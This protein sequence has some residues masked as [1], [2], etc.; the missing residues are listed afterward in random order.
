[1]VGAGLGDDYLGHRWAYARNRRQLLE[2]AGERAHLLLDP[3]RKFPDRGGELVKDP[4]PFRLRRLSIECGSPSGPHRHCWLSTTPW[5]SGVRN[6]VV[7]PSLCDGGVQRRVPNA[8]RIHSI[9][10]RSSRACTTSW[11]AVLVTSSPISHP[12]PYNVADP[13]GHGLYVLNRLVNRD[14]HRALHV[15]AYKDGSIRSSERARHRA[16][17]RCPTAKRWCGS[18]DGQSSSSTTKRGAGQMASYRFP[19]GGRIG[20]H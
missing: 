17:R 5:H 15:L 18:G 11:R 14:K 6:G 7:L 12:Q 2:L 20:W 8:L 13:T 16:A 19:R 10:S 1:M 4:G 3:R 9:S